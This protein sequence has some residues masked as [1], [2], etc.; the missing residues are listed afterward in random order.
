MTFGQRLKQ[1]RID[2]N[3]SQ[4]ELA[5]AVGIDPRSISRYE[6]GKSTPKLKVARRIAVALG[7]TVDW[8]SGKTGR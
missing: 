2:G 7:V 6:T 5:E 3:M 4:E 8:L 1:A